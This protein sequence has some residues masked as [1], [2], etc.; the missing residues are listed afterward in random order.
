MMSPP[1]VVLVACA[2]GKVAA[3]TVA[4]DLYVSTLFRAARRFAET[5]GDRWY[6]LSALHGVLE[7]AQIIAP[8]ECT[9]NSMRVAERRAW[10]SAINARLLSLLPKGRGVTIL[11]GRNYSEF[12]VPVL[13]EH[14]YAVDLPL[15]HL[16][17]GKQ[18]QWL[19]RA[20]ARDTPNP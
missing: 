9:L 12:I 19:Q 10:A 15:A 18:V 14:G 1:P 20:N 11:A 7:P 6:I 2:A 5:H 16:P 3:P 17:I 8:Y 4:R 13:R